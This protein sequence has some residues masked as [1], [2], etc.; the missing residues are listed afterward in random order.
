MSVFPLFAHVSV[1]VLLQL[2]VHP[3]LQLPSQDPLL[4]Q[5][6][7]CVCTTDRQTL[8]WTRYS[9]RGKLITGRARVSGT[10]PT[11][12]IQNHSFALICMDAT[13]KLY[14]FCSF[15]PS[16][17]KDKCFL[18]SLTPLSRVRA[19]DSVLDPDAAPDAVLDT[20]WTQ[21]RRQTWHRT[22]TGAGCGTRHGTGQ[23]PELG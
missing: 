2:S 23:K 4:L 10:H 11:N 22:R 14:L 19:P 18:N 1:L 3:A 13:A 12:S 5:P 17:D 6:G 20:N 8:P 9:Q 16:G 7:V 21:T 15:L